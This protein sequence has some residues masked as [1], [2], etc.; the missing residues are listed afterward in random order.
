M[1]KIKIIY[2]RNRCIGA[3]TCAAIAPQYFVIASDQKADLAGSKKNK[4]TGKYEL[5]IE[6]DENE[7]A[8]LRA[9]ANSCPVQVIKVED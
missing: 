6:I 3:A 1:P 2:D 7:L 9:A 4:K 8:I 5:T